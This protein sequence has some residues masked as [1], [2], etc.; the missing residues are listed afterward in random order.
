[1]RRVH[2]SN[3]HTEHSR[4]KGS[5]SLPEWMIFWKI[6]GGLAGGS[7]AVWKFSE[8]SSI[9]ENTGFHVDHIDQDNLV[10]LWNDLVVL[11]GMTLLSFVSW[12]NEQPYHDG[13]H[14]HFPF[15]NEVRS[16]KRTL[17]EHRSALI[18]IN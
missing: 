8:N 3:G 11:D 5:L 15:K 9:S 1:M 12:R 18:S 13:C 4:P 10:E 6:S 2:T 14:Q 16:D 7:K 17:F